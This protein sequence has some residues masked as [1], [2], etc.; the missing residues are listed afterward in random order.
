MGDEPYELN[1]NCSLRLVVTFLLILLAAYRLHD[2]I[3]ITRDIII[4]QSRSIY[5]GQHH[6]SNNETFSKYSTVKKCIP[7]QHSLKPN[8]TVPFLRPSQWMKGNGDIYSGMWW[9]SIDSMLQTN[10]SKLGFLEAVSLKSFQ[11]NKRVKQTVDWLDVNVEH[12]SKYVKHFSGSKVEEDRVAEL[13]YDYIERTKQHC[14]EVYNVQS[15]ISSTIAILPLRVSSLEKKNQVRLL[16]LQ[17][18]ATLA[19]LWAAGFP[20]ALVVGVCHNESIVARESFNLLE[21]HLTIQFMDLKYIQIDTTDM[22][23]VPKVALARFQEIIMQPKNPKDTPINITEQ[24]K[25]LGKD[26]LFRWK[27]VYFTEPDLVLHIRPEAMPSLSLE[28]ARGHIINAH[29]LQLLPHIQQFSGIVESIDSSHPN[30]ASKLRN[31]VLPNA[32]S[33]GSIHSLNPSS[34]DVCC[35]QGKFYPSHID[36][37]TSPAIKS[38]GCWLWEFCGFGPN[39]NHSDWNAVVKNHELLVM[40]PFL[41]LE[42]GTRIPV[43]HHGQ[44]VCTARRDGTICSSLDSNTNKA[45]E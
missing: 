4:T 7:R 37:P 28:L 9:Q 18:T 24:T 6:V 38:K 19:S 32:A 29:R 11:N 14:P 20:R 15:A 5:D 17:L 13:I 10:Y 23:L 21:E 22:K 39:I 1:F 33:F 25:W 34:G 27:Y 43:V 2:E 30:K 8:Y 42:Q 40:H 35:D 41:S 3:K 44:R 31:K 36:N 16:R 12:L 26:N 45:R